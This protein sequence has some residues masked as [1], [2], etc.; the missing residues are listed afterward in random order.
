MRFIVA[1]HF[2]PPLLSTEKQ[3]LIAD[4]REINTAQINTT[5]SISP[6]CPRKAFKPLTRQYGPKCLT[7]LWACFSRS[8]V[9][10]STV[11][12]WS[13]GW[14]E[15][16]QRLGLGWG[17]GYCKWT[18]LLF[19]AMATGH[20]SQR[21]YCLCPGS[22]IK[23]TYGHDE[24]ASQTHSFICRCGWTEEAMCL[25]LIFLAPPPTWSSHRPSNAVVPFQLFHVDAK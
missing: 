3:P 24:G 14:L 23:G 18:A 8:L 1:S 11:E 19:D 21:W 20:S 4:K 6:F 10:Q 2:A 17:L 22:D 16:G 13:V 5:F 25:W 7:Y 15:Q 12:I 9:F